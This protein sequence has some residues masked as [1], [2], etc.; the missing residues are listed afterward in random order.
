MQDPKRHAVAAFKSF[1]FFTLA[2]GDSYNDTAMLSEAD[3]GFF[4]CPPEQLP[5]EFPQFPVTLSYQELRERFAMAGQFA[6]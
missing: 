5:R 3:A 1:N 6:V 4:F 2:A